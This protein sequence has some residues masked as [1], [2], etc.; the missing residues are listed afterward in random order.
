MSTVA[1][2]I[3]A[4]DEEAKGATLDALEASGGGTSE[5]P[6]IQEGSQL[7]DGGNPIIQA[8]DKRRLAREELMS[9]EATYVSRTHHNPPPPSIA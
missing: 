8:T 4:A 6:L 7:F 1:D 9:S 2:I 5:A 3:F